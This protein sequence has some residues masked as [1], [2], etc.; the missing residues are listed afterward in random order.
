MWEERVLTLEVLCA[1]PLLAGLADDLDRARWERANNALWLVVRRRGH[2]F[3]ECLDL[4]LLLVHVG[5]EQLLADAA[6]DERRACRRVIHIERL[7][8]RRRPLD[9]A[10]LR[11][12]FAR[13]RDHDARGRHLGLFAPPHGLGPPRVADHDRGGGRAQEAFFSPVR[14]LCDLA[15]HHD[16]RPFAEG[17]AVRRP[18]VL[19]QIRP[20][21]EKEKTQ[22]QHLYIIIT[23]VRKS[24]PNE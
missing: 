16:D 15:R 6:A 3:H 18:D 13:N 24:I 10:L 2:D 23:I 20:V 11:Y 14:L 21:K 7:A 17:Q 1:L 8:G 9:T 4:L 5:D 19:I 22:N 12:G